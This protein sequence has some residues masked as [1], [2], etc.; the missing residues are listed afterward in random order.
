MTATGSVSDP[1]LREERRRDLPEEA[2]KKALEKARGGW[3]VVYPV[4]P[5]VCVTPKRY[6]LY[7][8]HTIYIYIHV[9]EW[10]EEVAVGGIRGISFD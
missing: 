5:T 8:I 1:G 2:S 10:L 9:S 7:T 3:Q 4:W 6:T